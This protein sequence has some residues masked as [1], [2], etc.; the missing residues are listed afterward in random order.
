VEVLAAVNFITAEVWTA[1]GLITYYLLMFMRVASR[2]VYIAGL[3][4]SPDQRWMDEMARN[5]SFAD[6]GFL[7]GCRRLLHNRDAKSCNAFTGI[8][9][10]G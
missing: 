2:E 3:T 6:N 9:E 10:A 4:T 8:L 5:I 7:K 1:G